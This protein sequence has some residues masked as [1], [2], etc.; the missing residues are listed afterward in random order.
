M[1]FV[2]GT[3]VEGLG[4]LYTANVCVC[5]LGRLATG[6]HVPAGRFYAD[7]LKDLL[8]IAEEAGSVSKLQ[9]PHTTPHH[10]THHTS[11]SLHTG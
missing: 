10:T 8:A 7:E 6:L 2:S 11:Y 9:T 4:F 3:D 1:I 5:V